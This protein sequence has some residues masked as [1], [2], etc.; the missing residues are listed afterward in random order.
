MDSPHGTLGAPL[1]FSQFCRW[2]R[3]GKAGSEQFTM[4]ARWIGC[5]AF[6]T[7]A[8]LGT[9]RIWGRRGGRLAL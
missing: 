6:R 9:A 8:P 2:R 1:N 5:G 7:D 3:V 4:S